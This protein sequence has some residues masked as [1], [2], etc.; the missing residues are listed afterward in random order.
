MLGVIATAGRDDLVKQCVCED[1]ESFGMPVGRSVFTTCKWMGQFELQW[2]MSLKHW[3]Y[4]TRSEVKIELCG[5]MKAKD[6]NIRQAIIDKYG[7]TKKKAIG[8][9]KAKGPLYGIKSHVWSALALAI[10]G[11]KI[12]IRT[13]VT[14]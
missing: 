1:I 11:S 4:I 7:E 14:V 5:S 10:V 3:T 9:K 8:T 12:T 13:G 2:K 6:S